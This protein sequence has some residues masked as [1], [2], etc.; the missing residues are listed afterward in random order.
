MFS[1]PGKLAHSFLWWENF[2][3]SAQPNDF[4]LIVRHRADFHRLT[5][6]AVPEL[7]FREGKLLLT[8][9]G[10]GNTLR[11]TGGRCFTGRHERKE[12]PRMSKKIKEKRDIPLWC[13]RTHHGGRAVRATRIGLRWIHHSLR[14]LPQAGA[15]RRPKGRDRALPPAPPA[16]SVP[17]RGIQLKYEVRRSSFT[18]FFPVISSKRKSTETVFLLRIALM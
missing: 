13:E 12:M 11:A 15:R 6:P 2:R 3:F 16:T 1:V 10:R 18:Y 9:P 5:H 7:P 4:F 17:V 8:P 14:E